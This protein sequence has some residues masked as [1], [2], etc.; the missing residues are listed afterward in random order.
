MNYKEFEE[1]M[2]SL[3]KEESYNHINLTIHKIADDKVSI[4]YTTMYSN[5]VSNLFNFGL[6][7]VELFGTKAIDF[8][9]EIANS[10]CPTCDYYSEYGH[11]FIID[12]IT[13]NM[14][15]L[16]QFCKNY[17]WDKNVYKN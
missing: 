8:D 15:N 1:K 7:L 13:K 4:T 16:N 3:F 6:E 2:F 12:K 17:G 11:V 9:E 14:D 5:P 10:G